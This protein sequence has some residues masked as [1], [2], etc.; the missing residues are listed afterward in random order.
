MRKIPANTIKR[1]IVINEEHKQFHSAKHHQRQFS[2][3]RVDKL[4]AVL[5]V[6]SRCM[7][8]VLFVSGVI[9]SRAQDIHFSLYEEAGPI[10]NPGLT[11][12]FNGNFRATTN[13]RNQWTSLGTPYRTFA[14]AFDK[15]VKLKSN[16]SLGVGL[17]AFRDVAGSTGLSTT[18]VAVNLAGLVNLNKQQSISVGLSGG[19]LQKSIDPGTFRWPD[20]YQGG[21]FNAGNATEEVMVAESAMKFNLSTGV[22]WQ[23]HS[24]SKSMVSNDQFRA[25]A[26]LAYHHVNQPQIS[27]L[28]NSDQSINPKWI[29][30]SNIFIGI[31]STNLA[32]LPS[33]FVAL[34]GPAQ[35]IVTG[36]MLRMLLQPESKYT[37]LHKE[38]ACSMGLFYRVGDALIPTLLL[39]L[40]NFRIGAAYDITVSPLGM[41]NAGRGGIEFSLS[42]VT[43]NPFATPPKKKTKRS[44]LL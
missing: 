35:E 42:Y 24:K 23:Y 41:A 38:M 39:E 4:Q 28:E 34:Q 5:T 3:R 6:F 30:H 36:S 29:F 1:D 44:S 33:T 40:S 12:A 32:I 18:D 25:A 31:K 11:G 10:I 27:F 43:P 37:K 9:E 22:S 16:S 26:G 2:S 15:R 19:I 13:A 7:V 21:A 14:A 8:V 20:Q 17:H